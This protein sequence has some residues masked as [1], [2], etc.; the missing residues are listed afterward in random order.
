MGQ[1][2]PAEDY[3]F[4]YGS[5]RAAVVDEARA[6]GHILSAHARRVGEASMQGRLY[7]VSWYPGFEPGRSRMERVTGDIWRIRDRAALFEALD[8]Y[9]GREYVR[10]R[11]IARLASGVKISAWVYIYAADLNGAPQIPS[12]DFAQWLRANGS[13]RSSRQ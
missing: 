6:A 13:M 9:E 5:L 11:R 10:A 4:V 12:G 3:L 2:R 1:S 7:A 8:N